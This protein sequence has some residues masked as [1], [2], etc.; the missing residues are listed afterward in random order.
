M[1]KFCNNE[2]SIMI[3]IRKILCSDEVLECLYGNDENGSVENTFPL[4]KNMD[5]D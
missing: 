1:L 2:F 4:E 5:G 3:Y